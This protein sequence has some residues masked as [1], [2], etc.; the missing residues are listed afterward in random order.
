MPDAQAGHE[1][2]ITSLLPALAGANLIYGMGMLELG[3]TFSFGQLMIDNE[4]AGMV[5]R[6]V[7]GIRVADD[8]LA[9]EL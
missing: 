4:I 7:Q 5:K 3:V 1:K 6:V 9:V 8:T 2:T